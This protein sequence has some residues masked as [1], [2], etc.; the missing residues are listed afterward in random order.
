MNKRQK[1]KLVRRALTNQVA[2]DWAG[3][4]IKDIPCPN[5]VPS[6]FYA[7]FQ[8]TLLGIIDREYTLKMHGKLIFN[9]SPF[10]VIASKG[11]E[12]FTITQAVVDA[13]VTKFSIRKPI[14]PTQKDVAY[15][16]NYYKGILKSLELLN[17]FMSG[18]KSPVDKIPAVMATKRKPPFKIHKSNVERIV[19]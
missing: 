4:Y 12:R 17:G 2:L 10:D 3:Q 11:E 9:Y 14:K 7:I 13:F 15:Y 1:K 16:V 19:I 18:I 6:D 8:R 5:S